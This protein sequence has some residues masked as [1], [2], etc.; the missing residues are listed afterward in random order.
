M[1]IDILNKEGKK[2][3]TM[4]LPKEVFDVRW[5]PEAV[6]QSLL[7]TAANA[8][9][10]TAHTKSRGEVS[11]GGKKPWRQKGTGRARHG[12]IRSPIWKGGGVAFGPRNE[13]VFLKKVN[14]KMKCFALASI[15]SKRHKE[16]RFFV[17][18]SLA[19]EPAKTHTVADF[20]KRRVG[21]R[22]SVLFVRDSAN[23][24]LLSAS[25]NIPRVEVATPSSLDVSACIGKANIIFEAPALEALVARLKEDKKGKK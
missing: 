12:S 22:P 21:E 1:T 13:R 24:S 11:G 20:L 3:G 9:V 19:F 17:Y 15:L 18:D 8:R 5:S 14:K 4:A 2:T 16:K 23:R 7:A 10:S 6:H 25:R